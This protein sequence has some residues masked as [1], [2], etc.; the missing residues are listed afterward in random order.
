MALSIET[1]IQKTTTLLGLLSDP[2]RFRI[3]LLLLKHPRGLYVYE[4]AEGVGV[5]H[6]GVSH[7]LGKLEAHH[8]VE[9]Y[10]DGKSICYALVKNT[11]TRSVRRIVQ[12]FLS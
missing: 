12:I 8:V 7:Q 3:V 9:G 2:T 10:R 1:K 4:I 6:S 11:T 5:S